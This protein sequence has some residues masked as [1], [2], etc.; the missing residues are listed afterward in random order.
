MA[1]LSVLVISGSRNDSLKTLYINATPKSERYHDFVSHLALFYHAVMSNSAFSSLCS[2]VC[3]SVD[4]STNSTQQPNPSQFLNML[5]IFILP[6]QIQGS[7]FENFIY[8]NTRN[9]THSSLLTNALSTFHFIQLRVCLSARTQ[10][11][12]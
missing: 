10:I 5:I 12:S 8:T 9:S 11:C 1:I 7:V 6:P 3:W 2:W 4:H